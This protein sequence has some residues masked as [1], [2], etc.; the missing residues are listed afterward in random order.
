MPTD[1]QDEAHRIQYW[2]SPTGDVETQTVYSR[3][4]G[5]AI[6]AAIP[7]SAR[8]WDPH[9]QVW[10]FDAQ[11]AE[12]ALELA[13]AFFTELVALDELPKRARRP[14]TEHRAYVTLHLLTSAPLVVA[15]ASYVALCASP[16]TTKQQRELD[17]AI[18]LIRLVQATPE[19]PS[20][21]TP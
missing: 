4:W 17:E 16:P 10:R 18:A 6:R 5:D 1:L 13:E 2:R 11:Y 3:A 8:T 14:M 15:E 7:Q 9:R 19:T 20:P 21:D 12:V